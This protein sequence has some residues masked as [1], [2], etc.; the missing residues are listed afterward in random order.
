VKNEKRTKTIKHTSVAAA[1][2]RQI[3]GGGAPTI[4][5]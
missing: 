5:N 2:R 3:I 1:V 4:K